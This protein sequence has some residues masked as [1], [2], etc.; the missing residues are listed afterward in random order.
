MGKC[1]SRPGKTKEV[2]P[3][4][5]SQGR[6]NVSGS[7][8]SG[9]IAE[10]VGEILQS[11]E[12]LI[13]GFNELKAA[14]NDFNQNNV[15]DQGGFGRVYKA[16]INEQ[17]LTA[18]LPETGLAVSVKKLDQNGSHGLQEWLTEIRQQGPLVHPNIVKL[19][20][21]CLENNCRLLVYEYMPNGT[22]ENH[23][24]R[25]ESFSWN[26]RMTIAL[27]AAR[28]LAF[29][30]NK[31][32]VIFRDFNTSHILLDLDFNAKLSYFGLAR[33]GP[34]DGNTHITTRVLGTEWYLAPEY[35][36][37]GYLRK[38]GDVY[39]FGVVLL[40]LLSGRRAMEMHLESPERNLVTWAKP[41]LSKR[42]SY[43][44]VIDRHLESQ[45]SPSDGFEAAQLAM[46]CL[47]L[48]PQK[49]PKMEEVVE[50]LQQLA[51]SS[52]PS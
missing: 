16:W 17:S 26:Q 50:A 45:F 36:K 40:E 2:K 20:G 29:L 10:P 42:R 47:S 52:L 23:L 6:R 24:F 46:Q 49:R 18:A 48:E 33:D 51:S 5:G 41:Y 15:L 14:T 28:G 13:F 35:D 12:L 30:H 27:G 3:R 34:M 7:I 25:F 19:I 11:P 37:S 4:Y 1:L 22:L 9:A 8:T 43:F 21:Y 44:R 32:N 39:S 38:S 31:A